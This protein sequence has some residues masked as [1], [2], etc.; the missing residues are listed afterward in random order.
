MRYYH[1]PLGV[2]LKNTAQS[3]ALLHIE[4]IIEILE[5]MCDDAEHF[6]YLKFK[7]KSVTVLNNQKKYFFSV[8]I[9]PLDLSSMLE[10]LS[11]T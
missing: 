10:C 11:N 3:R 7:I 9:S 6:V 2:A 4:I 8:I 1:M 5:C